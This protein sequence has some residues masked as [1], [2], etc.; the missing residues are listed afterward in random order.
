MFKDGPM[1]Q[2]LQTKT[3]LTKTQILEE[4]NRSES[5]R[6]KSIGSLRREVDIPAIE[7]EV[8][9]IAV[10]KLKAENA[11][12]KKEVRRSANTMNEL[13]KL[14]F[15]ELLTRMNGNAFTCRMTQ[16]VK[17]F[18]DKVTVVTLFMNDG[19]L[20]TQKVTD[21]KPPVTI[22]NPLW[23]MDFDIYRNKQP[24]SFGANSTYHDNNTRDRGEYQSRGGYRSR[25][26]RGLSNNSNYRGRGGGKWGN[27][28]Y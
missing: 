6:L 11:K 8:T 15:N 27:N 17:S 16:I 14:T 12:L 10:N 20:C 13:N 19:T 23:T 4:F 26:G 9:R 5:K 3:S 2:E 18:K 1:N 28:P 25:G 22:D 21:G 24:V 7:D